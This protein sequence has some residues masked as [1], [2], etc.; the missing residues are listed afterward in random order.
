MPER[1]VVICR[2]LTKIFE[3][4]WRG[5]PKELLESFGEKTSKGEFVVIISPK[6]WEIR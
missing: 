1:F 2:E 4:T 3:E 6:N 5:T